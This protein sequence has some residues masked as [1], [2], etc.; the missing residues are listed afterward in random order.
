[1]PYIV[2]GEQP[3]V[4]GITAGRH[5][6]AGVAG[7]MDAREL[8]ARRD[9]GVA[10]ARRKEGIAPRCSLQYILSLPAKKSLLAACV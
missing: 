2:R 6:D 4:G 9:G 8:A 3:V 10:A 7:G 1:M 5:P